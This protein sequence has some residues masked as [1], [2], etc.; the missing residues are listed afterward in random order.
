MS[1]LALAVSFEY[2]YYGLTVI[3][4]ILIPRVRGLTLDVRI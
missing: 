2:L 4:N 3:T 1:Q